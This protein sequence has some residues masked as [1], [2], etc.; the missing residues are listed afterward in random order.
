MGQNITTVLLGNGFNYSVKDFI[1]DDNLKSEIGSI[2]SLWKQF[3]DLIKTKE[4]FTEKTIEDLYK[5]FALISLVKPFEEDKKLSGCINALKNKFSENFIKKL[6]DIIDE[7]ANQENR[8]FYKHLTNFLYSGD[9]KNFNLCKMIT[10]NHI[11]IYTTNYDGI[12]EM[13]FGYDGDKF[14]LHDGFRGC[15]NES[16]E[17]VCFNEGIFSNKDSKDPKLLHLHGSYKFFVYNFLNRMN[18]MEIKTKK[19]YLSNFLRTSDKALFEP[20]VVL[21]APS[22]KEKQVSNFRILKKYFSSF[23][24]DLKKSNKLVIWGQSLKSD[25][26]IK[27][28]IEQYF[29]KDNK[30]SKKL[31]IIDTNDNHILCNEPGNHKVEHINPTGKNFI[32]LLKEN[33]LNEQN[34]KS[35]S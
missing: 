6:W 30:D 22:L 8:G 27:K 24:N 26:H 23:E 25:P 35:N 10:R 20:I 1:T 19:E 31:I 33:I 9:F 34:L 2:I 14:G 4:S 3:D 17:Y 16:R 11:N 15:D 7:F 13:I 5:S 21:N 12:A 18:Y 28:R 32:Q 29:T